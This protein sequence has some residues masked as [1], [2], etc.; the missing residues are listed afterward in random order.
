MSPGR[1]SLPLWTFREEKS[2]FPSPIQS[3]S[4]ISSLMNAE[5]MTVI[6]YIYRESDKPYLSVYKSVQ[7]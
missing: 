6:I 2:P 4:P 5:P 1:P 7:E 3:Y